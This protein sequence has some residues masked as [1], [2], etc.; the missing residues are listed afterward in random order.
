MLRARRCVVS[1][2]G[3]WATEDLLAASEDSDWRPGRGRGGEAAWRQAQ[4]DTPACDSFMH[5]HLV[6]TCV[7]LS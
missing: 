3:T 2:A 5:L 7:L 1:N 4:R 6:R